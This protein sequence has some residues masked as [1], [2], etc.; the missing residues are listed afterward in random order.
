MNELT[1]PVA[2]DLGGVAVPISAVCPPDEHLV[3]YGLGKLTGDGADT[4]SDHLAHCRTCV[5]RLAALSADSFAGKLRQDPSPSGTA[6]PGKS[7]SGLARSIPESA[8][9]PAGELPPEFAA[10]P[11]YVD[12]RELGR[13]G[14]GVVYLATN[15]LMNRPE[16]LKVVGRG[17]LTRPGARERFLQE[18]P[19]AARLQ[20]RNVVTAYAVTL[21]G[22]S[23]VFAMEYVPGEDLAKVVKASGRL[24]VQ[25]A[26][27]YVAQA[28]AGLR[29]AHDR[30]MVH[31]DIKPANLIL[32]RDGPKAVVKILD[33]GLA[34]VTS[35]Q[36]QAPGLTREGQM[37]GTPD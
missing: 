23:V 27:Y 26:C 9:V 14:M 19:S 34:K 30:G 32:A 28:A 22:E 4:V 2:H 37:M 8:V 5:D 16:V 31:R 10:P 35:E 25:H 33:F 18:V 12:V 24:P 7:L 20:H 17:H 21:V 6:P 29:H 11:Q 15:R 13:G 1:T 3:A 36:E